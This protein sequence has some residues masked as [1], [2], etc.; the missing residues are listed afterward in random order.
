MTKSYGQ[1]EKEKKMLERFIYAFLTLFLVSFIL[2]A[3]VSEKI[4]A[5]FAEDEDKISKLE[6]KNK[7]L[8][9]EL[10]DITMSGTCLKR[11]PAYER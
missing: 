1:L 11:I 8:R 5:A 6:A 10:S 3:M 9:D 7:V 2:L 4:D